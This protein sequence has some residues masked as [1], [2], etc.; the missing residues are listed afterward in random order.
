MKIVWQFALFSI[1]GLFSAIGHYGT[2]IGLRELV[3]IEPVTA[4]LAGYLVGGT[5][6]YVLNYRF[7]FR[8]TKEHRE[9]LTKF[10]GVA[11]VGFVLN[12]VLMAAFTGPGKLHYLIAQILTTLVILLWSYSSNRYWTFRER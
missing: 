8:S 6:S 7:T 4:S 3:G 5:I 1:V 12:G 2:L 11:A 9:A 10:L